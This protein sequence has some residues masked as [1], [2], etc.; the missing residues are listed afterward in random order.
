MSAKIKI[1]DMKIMQEEN[2][3]AHIVQKDFEQYRYRIPNMVQERIEHNVRVKGRTLRGTKYTKSSE[4][5]F[6]Q[7][8]YIPRVQIQSNLTID[9][10]N[11]NW[12]HP[13]KNESYN[14]FTT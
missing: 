13:I 1:K 11:P 14:I 7:Y 6:Q 8:S 5:R 4:P 12:F 10:T 9:L 2:R 3:A